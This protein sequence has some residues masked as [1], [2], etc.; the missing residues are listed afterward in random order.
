MID[1]VAR[2]FCMRSVVTDPT[3]K[4]PTNK[5]QGKMLNNDRVYGEQAND[6]LV[7][8]EMQPEDTSCNSNNRQFA[9]NSNEQ[10]AS[11]QQEIR[12]TAALEN[13]I[14]EIKSFMKVLYTK[15]LNKEKQEKIAREWKL[16]A[17]VLDRLFFFSY[18]V[19]ILV[20]VLTV[21]DFVIFGADG[22]SSK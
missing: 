6:R 7:Y 4:K 8:T 13:D 12:S 19:I 10:V 11:L 14:K 16:V 3:D 21:F 18:L 2:I 17:L 20:S 1:V 9:L 15:N 22:R 5:R